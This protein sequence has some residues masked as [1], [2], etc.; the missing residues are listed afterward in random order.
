MQIV[1]LNTFDI[2]PLYQP[3][4]GTNIF[5][6][7]ITKYVYPINNYISSSNALIYRQYLPNQYSSFLFILDVSVYKNI[8]DNVTYY[9]VNNNNYYYTLYATNPYTNIDNI[10]ICWYQ[11]V[12]YDDYNMIY[13]DIVPLSNGV[14]LGNIIDY[15]YTVIGNLTVY[16]LE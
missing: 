5:T 3:N 14:N 9:E 10:H 7:S 11:N 15:K 4:N 8:F 6:N 13:F 1:K 12:S 2:L 16:G